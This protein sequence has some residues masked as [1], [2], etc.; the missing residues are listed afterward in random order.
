MSA[1]ECTTRNNTLSN[2]VLAA[3]NKRRH[4]QE[5]CAKLRSGHCMI[6]VLDEYDAIFKDQW[7]GS[8]DL[9]IRVFEGRGFQV[10]RLGRAISWLCSRVRVLGFRL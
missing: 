8:V 2:A 6:D 3:Q 10:G 7:P 4:L 9:Y 5:N 1:G